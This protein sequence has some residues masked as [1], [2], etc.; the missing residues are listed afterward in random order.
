MAYCG[1]A[2]VDASEWVKSSIQKG[3]LLYGD[4]PY[5]MMR[6]A[7]L[8]VRYPIARSAHKY[9]YN[10]LARDARLGDFVSL[11]AEFLPRTAFSPAS[12]PRLRSSFQKAAP[13]GPLGIHVV[14]SRAP[15]PRVEFRPDQQ[16]LS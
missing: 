14:L 12:P 3:L 11:Q 2:A 5:P 6:S 8:R 1:V 4:I 16:R 13:G 9:Q 10:S 7:L 15:M